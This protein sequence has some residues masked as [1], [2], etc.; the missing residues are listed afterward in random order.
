M[1]PK[2]QKFIFILSG[3][4]I[5]IIL[6]L[7]SCK[8]ETIIEPSPPSGSSLPIDTIKN[9]NADTA[10]TGAFTYFSLRT[11]TIITGQDTLSNLWDVAFRGT[12]IWINGG[13]ARFGQ[14]GAFIQRLSNFDTVSAA[15]VSGYAVDSSDTQLAI[16]TGSG[17]GWYNYDGGTNTIFPIQGTVLIIKTAG[18]KY[19]KLEIMSYYKNSIPFPNPDPVN[20][21]W[22][23]FR[24]SLQ[25]DGS[26]KL[27]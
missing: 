7:S 10:N 26:T 13:P 16:P 12:T 3:I 2:K 17:N 14:G 4:F 21:R 27:K 9:L 18:G 1:N 20:Y 11:K 6:V 5:F 19:S 24:Y 8:E 22:Y 23:T 15:P 25:T